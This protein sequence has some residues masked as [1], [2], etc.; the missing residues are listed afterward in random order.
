[1]RKENGA[2]HPHSGAT[3]TPHGGWLFEERLHFVKESIPVCFSG[4]AAFFG[5][6]GQQ[7]FLTGCEL[8]RNLHLDIEDMISGLMALEVRHAE[9]FQPKDFVVL[10]AGRN[11]NDRGSFQR[12]DLHLPAQRGRD[13]T[14]RDITGDVV[15]FPAEDTMGFDGD[16]DVEIA[17]WT[18]IH[19]VLAFIGKA[20]AHAGFNTGRNLDGESPLTIY[21]LAA[22]AGAAG[23]GDDLSCAAA[24]STWA[25]DAE[26][27]L[28]KPELACTFATGADLDRPRRSRAGA[29][30]V[31]ADLPARN[32]EFGLFAVNRFFEAEFEVIL[33]VIAPLGAASST[34]RAEKIL[35]DVVK[36]VAEPALAEVK[37]IG[38][39]GTLLGIGVAEYVVAL[40]L[41]LIAQDFVRF[42]DFLEFFLGGFLLMVASLKIWMVLTGKLSVGFLQLVVG[43]GTFDPQHFVIITFRRGS[44]ADSLEM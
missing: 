5:E 31:L 42:V 8:R 33:K 1:M 36:H 30:T 34:W 15:P 14:D 10:C 43:G 20:Q 12:G 18:G 27:A 37:A 23:F 26:E 24:L 40:P 7:L 4:H 11:L 16:R 25:A 39:T 21:P 32:L 17:R 38:A 35:E 6:I 41:L 29:F 9:T 3:P 19:S 2:G 28:L 44:H 13:E 22:L